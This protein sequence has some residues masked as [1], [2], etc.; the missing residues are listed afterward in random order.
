MKYLAVLYTALALTANAAHADIAAA[1]AARD[2]T[3]K[4]LLFQGASDVSDE[5]F[6]DPDGGEFRLSDFRGKHV[7][8]NFWATWCAPCR[9]EMPMLSELQSEFGGDAFEVVTIATGRNSV[10]GIRKF[11]EETGVH[12]LPL[13][14]DPKSKLGRDMDVLGLPITVI[15]DPAGREIA[16]MR[17]DAE[18]NSESG[19]AVVRALIGTR[20]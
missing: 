17:G 16:R 12:N 9:K 20:G 5:V 8:V 6:T 14:L 10:Q 11:F 2:G 15:L 18:W 13:Y 3:M 19:K 7:L 1:E 4:K